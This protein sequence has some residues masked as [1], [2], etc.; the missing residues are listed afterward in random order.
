MG[1]HDVTVG[2][3]VETEFRDSSSLRRKRHISGIFYI[4]LLPFLEFYFA[5]LQ[6]SNDWH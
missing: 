4:H 3:L 1:I 5:S 6:R 2:N